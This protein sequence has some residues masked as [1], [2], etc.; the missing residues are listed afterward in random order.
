[1]CA[2]NKRLPQ[3]SFS[4]FS[5]NPAI[6]RDTTGSVDVIEFLL[7]D[8]CVVLVHNTLEELRRLLDGHCRPSRQ[9]SRQDNLQEVED[10]I[11]SR[12]DRLQLGKVRTREPMSLSPIRCTYPSTELGCYLVDDTPC[13]PNLER[14]IVCLEQSLEEL[15]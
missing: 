9:N 7:D 2:H 5:T 4:L 1:M 3:L 15:L 8:G 12:C 14:D 6:P 10:V 11:G 13:V